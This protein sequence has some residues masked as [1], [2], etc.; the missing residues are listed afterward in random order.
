MNEFN[1]RFLLLL[2]LLRCFRCVRLCATP[3][4]A[5]HQA[6]LPLG[7]CRQEY[8][9]GFPFPSPNLRLDTAKAEIVVFPSSSVR[10]ETTYNAGDVCSIPGL[11]R[12]S[13]EG[14]G[15][16]LQYACLGRLM[17]RGTRWSTVHWVTK[18]HTQLSD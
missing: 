2:L 17:E 18:N 3:L 10:K 9:S 5:A 11:G 15:N 6:P 7:F 1:L 4:T 8:W 13:R 16:L 12:F 14:N